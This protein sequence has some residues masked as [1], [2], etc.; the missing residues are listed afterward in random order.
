MMRCAPILIAIGLCARLGTVRAQ[1]TDGQQRRLIDIHA[2]L[3]D[4]PPGQAPAALTSG[5]VGASVEAVGIP[6]IDGTVAD[7]RELTASDHTR[8]FPR[9]RLMLGLPAPPGLRIFVGLSY[10]PPIRIRQVSTNYGAAEGGVGVAPGSL[11]LGARV[12]AVY[13]WTSA[14]VTDPQTRDLLKTWNAGVDLSAGVQLG[15]GALHVEPYA[16]AGMV[17][18]RSHFHVAVDG[19]TLQ[20]SFTGLALHAGLRFGLASRWEVVTETDAY[21]GRLFHT[22]LRVG[23]LFGG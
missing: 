12:H 16:G 14:P 9:P 8:V 19:T 21:P 20:S 7:K 3:L 11:R 4:L 22:D 15:R 2:L 5:T 6:P 18:V 17:S 1:D 13:A 10:I 23:Y